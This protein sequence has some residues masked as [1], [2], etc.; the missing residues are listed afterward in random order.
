MY[1]IIFNNLD[2]MIF[3]SSTGRQFDK[4]GNNKNWWD[5]GK[6]KRSYNNYFN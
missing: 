2:A 5:S 3:N 6:N 4:D 1:L